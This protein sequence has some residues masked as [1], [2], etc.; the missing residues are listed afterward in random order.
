MSR[1]TLTFN[2]PED[3]CEAHIATHAM[4]WAMV[5]LDLDEWL[6]RQMKYELG[7]V[8]ELL[9]DRRG[10]PEGERKLDG[11][12]LEAVREL[13]RRTLDGRGLALE[14]IE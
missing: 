14:D 2:L 3:C 5:A 10:T 6:R 11:L 4:D 13:L 1:V 12:T 7:T 8:A 9:P